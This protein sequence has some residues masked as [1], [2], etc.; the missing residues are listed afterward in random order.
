MPNIKDA[1]KITSSVSPTASVTQWGVPVIV[2]ESSATAKETPKKFTS[3]E[4]LKT[5]HGESSDIYLGA[6][7]MYTQGVRTFYTLA[8]DAATPGSPTADEVEDALDTLSAYA[9]AGEIDGAVLAGITSSALLAKLKTFADAARLIFV[10]THDPEDTVSEIVAT[11]ATLESVNGFFV[12]CKSASGDVACAVLG[13]IMVRRPYYTLTWMT[14]I[15][16]ADDYYSP[17]DVATLE[18]GRVNAIIDYGGEDKLSNG[19]SLKSTVPFLDTTRTEYYVEGLIT[20]AVA[21]GRMATAQVP[22]NQKGFEVV[23]GWITTPLESLLRD[24]AIQGYS[25]AMPN[26]GDISDEDRAVRKITGVTIEVQ[27]VSDIQAF[28]LSLNIEV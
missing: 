11:A 13:A 18:D 22:Y 16:N 1:I 9:S 15:V 23:R 2:G 14:A 19:L 28:D 5:E 26:I 17:A 6:Y 12:A 24:N 20:S 3:L 25:V 8:I 4:L 21:A 7:A 10:V 27:T